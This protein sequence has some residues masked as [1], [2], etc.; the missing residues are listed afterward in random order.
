LTVP[1]LKGIEYPDMHSPATSNRLGRKRDPNRDPEILDAA[2]AVLGETGYEGMTMEMVAARAKAGKGTM[3]R[4]WRSKIELV[5]EAVI[6][7]AKRS[8][9]DPELLPDT[10]GLRSDLMAIFKRL[11]DE[12]ADPNLKVLAALTT[13]SALNPALADSVNKAFIEPWF[14][15]Y[16]TL[17]RRA[18]ARGEVSPKIDLAI[19][20]QIVP[21]MAAYRSL[22]LRK[23]LDNKFLKSLID[24]VL[25]PALSISE[26][27]K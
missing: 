15:V 18:I 17:I 21:S 10:G 6:H 27:K 11:P 23:P 7:L 14:A 13:M 2:L 22:I 8:Q 16:Q 19:V 5:T 1:E 3:Y 12:A 24:G 20:S 9:I 25:L 26:K 4:R